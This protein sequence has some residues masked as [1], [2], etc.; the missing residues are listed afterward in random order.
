MRERVS[1]AR[2][3]ERG[4]VGFSE[5]ARLASA[6]ADPGDQGMVGSVAQFGSLGSSG[7]GGGALD[8]AAQSLC[9]DRSKKQRPPREGLGEGTLGK[10]VDQVKA[11]RAG[12]RPR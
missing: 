2:V 5:P 1:G 6:L 9:S 10:I 8:M 4:D 11:D 7:F 12:S 3:R